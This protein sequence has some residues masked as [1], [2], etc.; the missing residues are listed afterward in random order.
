MGQEETTAGSKA[1]GT[2][3]RRVR[4]SRKLSLDAVEE[5]SVEFPERV[6]KSHL[7]RIENGLALPTFPR[8]MALGK[9][10]GVPI[11]AMAERFE[12]E[13]GRDHSIDLGERGIDEILAEVAALRA[14]GKYAEAL[15][16]CAALA[17]RL[18]T[19][20]PRATEVRLQ[21][22]NCLVH[23]GR[24][25][26]AKA[27][28]EELLSEDFSR[29]ELK[30]RALYMFVACCYRLERHTVALM[31]L[32]HA[33]KVAQ[34]VEGVELKIRADLA[35]T[36]GNVLAGLRRYDEALPYFDLAYRLYEEIPDP[37]EMC[38]VLAIQGEV[39]L[40]RGD[41]AA[42]RVALERSLEQSEARHYDRQTALALSNLA[43][44]EMLEGRGEEA[45][46]L[47]IRSNSLARP[48]EF[49][50]VVFRNCYLLWRLA[51]ERGDDGTARA[52]ERSLRSLVGRL[53]QTFP[54]VD[55]FRDY[56]RSAS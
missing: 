33:E 4:E 29:V 6:T 2:Y 54:E 12:T 27:E 45:E 25:E 38:R 31:A 56:L 55:A 11:A 7:S 44:V 15:Q 50:S 52:N 23:L 1:F 5:M 19:E 40:E 32:E 14:R 30:I 18:A 28:V 36:R 3:L 49:L 41:R 34:S 17:D 24:F 39:H 13:L 9:I 8:L 20:D 37:F 16:H 35:A 21:S 22:V 26:A 47:A 10:Y 46:K 43:K 51:L 42:A 53:Q 48:R